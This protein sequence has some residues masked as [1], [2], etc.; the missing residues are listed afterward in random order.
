MGIRLVNGQWLN[1]HRVSHK[2]WIYICWNTSQEPPPGIAFLGVA[3]PTLAMNE[4][5][6]Q[7][8]TAQFAV[9]SVSFPHKAQSLEDSQVFFYA[10]LSAILALV[11]HSVMRSV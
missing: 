2:G 1:Y 9:D 6:T 3:G 4:A 10:R 11:W 8:T 5:R 7:S